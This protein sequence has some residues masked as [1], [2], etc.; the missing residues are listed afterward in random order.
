MHR[1]G[2]ACLRLT[3]IT[4]HFLS[5]LSQIMDIGQGK[6]CARLGP[7]MTGG[8]S[9]I[10]ARLSS[11][12]LTGQGLRIDVHQHYGFSF[13]LN[14][15]FIKDGVARETCMEREYLTY[16]KVRHCLEHLKSRPIEGMYSCLYMAGEDNEAER[17]FR[18]TPERSDY[19]RNASRA[20]DRFEQTIYQTNKCCCN[21]TSR[22]DV[23]F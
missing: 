8:S 14:W 6:V 9:S 1:N 15:A 19:D 7:K 3:S 11:R 22:E 13:H 4:I 12:S 2:N 16:S 18:T 23:I 20:I 5:H 17:C 10:L 21:V